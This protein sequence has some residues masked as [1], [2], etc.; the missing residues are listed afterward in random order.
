MTFL[1]PSMLCPSAQRTLMLAQQRNDGFARRQHMLGVMQRPQAVLRRIQRLPAAAAAGLQSA[2][3]VHSFAHAVEQ[4]CANSIDAG[5]RRVTVTFHAGQLTAIVS[6]DG[7][8]VAASCFPLLGMRHCT[9][10]HLPA[11]SSAAAAGSGRGGGSSSGSSGGRTLGFRGVFLASLVE[12]ACVKFV[13]KAAGTFETLQKVLDG[14]RPAN[15]PASLALRPRSRQGTEV[16]ISEFL[17][18]QP[19][20]RRALTT[21]RLEIPSRLPAA[22]LLCSGAAHAT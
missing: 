13:S 1:V 5:A 17:E 16:F 9:S 8:G 10:K 15:T 6:D 3:C 19:V 2:C 11:D 21:Q 22:W 18:R 12:V 7:V 14:N 4:C 20:R